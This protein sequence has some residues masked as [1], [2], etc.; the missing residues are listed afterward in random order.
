MRSLENPHGQRSP[1]GD[2]PWGQKES[3]RTQRLSTAHVSDPDCSVQLPRPVFPVPHGLN[4]AS[5]IQ[6]CHPPGA[7]LAPSGSHLFIRCL[8]MVQSLSRAPLLRPLGLQPTRLLCPWDSPGKNTGVGCHVLL[9]KTLRIPLW[10]VFTLKPSFKD[11]PA[12]LRKISEI[13]E[14][15]PELPNQN[16]CN[17]SGS[18]SFLF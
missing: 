6:A 4:P 16:L 10:S 12:L 8:V 13:T 14:S 1:V 7:S 9:H 17:R 18:L 2:S 11:R 3:D 15:T 5:Q